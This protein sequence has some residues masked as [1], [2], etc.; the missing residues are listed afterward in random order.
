MGKPASMILAAPT[1]RL[2]SP[3]VIAEN[4]STAWPGMPAE[5]ANGTPSADTTIACAISAT[6]VV[7]SVTNQFRSSR[8]APV[9]GCSPL[10][11]AVPVPSG[12]PPARHPG[13]QAGTRTGGCAPPPVSAGVTVLALG[14]PPP[15]TGHPAGPFRQE[16]PQGQ[17]R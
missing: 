13:R 2:V 4:C 8:Y 10:L 3:E 5:S 11:R 1:M 6:R 14:A 16:A 7:K 12:Y 9:N 15:G 17:D